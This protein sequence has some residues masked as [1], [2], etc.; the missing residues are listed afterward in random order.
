MKVVFLFFQKTTALVA[1]N[2]IKINTSI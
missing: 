2:S 1:V